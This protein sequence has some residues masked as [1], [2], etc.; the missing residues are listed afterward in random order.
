MCTDFVVTPMN[1]IFKC[2]FTVAGYEI[3]RGDMTS[4]GLPI[5]IHHLG[6]IA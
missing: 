4:S 1:T 2:D 6:E 3:Y 5:N